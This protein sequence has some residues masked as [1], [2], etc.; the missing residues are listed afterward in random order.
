VSAPTKVAILL[1]IAGT[2]YLGVEPEP[3]VKGA[4][5]AAAGLQVLPAAAATASR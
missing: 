5:Q 4:K 2:V 1:A 3:L